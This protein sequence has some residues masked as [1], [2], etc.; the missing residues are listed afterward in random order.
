M[1]E[2]M[3]FGMAEETTV[4]RA[5]DATFGLLLDFFRRQAAS[6]EFVDVFASLTPDEQGKLQSMAG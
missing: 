1:A 5:D 4:R 2:L 3:G 6:P